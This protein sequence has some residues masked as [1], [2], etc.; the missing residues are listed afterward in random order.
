MNRIWLDVS[1]RIDPL[2]AEALGEIDRLAADLGI[3][4]DVNYF[5]RS[6]TTT[7][8]GWSSVWSDR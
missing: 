8:A 7:L 3:L 4:S 5:G 1:N 6:A 2:L